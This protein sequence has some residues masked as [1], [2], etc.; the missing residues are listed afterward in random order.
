MVEDQD[1]EIQRGDNERLRAVITPASAA[2]ELFF[3]VKKKLSD[4][5][6]RAVI[7]KSLDDGITITVPGD[8][9]TPAEA[10][11]AINKAD[12]QV[13]PNRETPPV[14]VHYDLTDGDD[15]TLAKGKLTV[16]PE[17]RRA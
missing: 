15:H 7:A 14:I 8:G 11:I 3:T 1:L 12:T 17:V 5:D 2:S 6:E 9:D 13:L 16:K 10:Q 4:P